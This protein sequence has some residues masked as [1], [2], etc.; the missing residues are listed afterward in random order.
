MTEP[1]RC[2]RKSERIVLNARVQL[3]RSCWASYRVKVFDVSQHGCKLEFV[4]RPKLDEHIWVK[5][6]GLEP[7]EAYVCWIDGFAVGVEFKKTIH[8][9]VFDMLIQRLR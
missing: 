2:A 1:I 7:L 3:R 5:F 4:E 9:A 8:P 6:E